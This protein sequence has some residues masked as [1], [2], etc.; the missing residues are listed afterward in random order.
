M[1]AA[2]RALA[3]ALLACALPAAAE[4]YSYTDEQGNRVFTDRPGGRAVELVKPRPTNSMPPAETRPI[5]APEPVAAPT[6]DSAT[7]R[8]SQLEVLTPQPDA[9]IR[10]NAG[11]LLVEVASTPELLPGH[12]YRLLLDG[13]DTE[14]GGGGPQFALQNIDRGTHQLTVQV[15]DESGASLQSS[16]PRTFHMMR[17]S[18]AQRRMARPCKKDDYGVRPECPLKDKPKEKRDIPFVPF[19]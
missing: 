18:L 15:I 19:L 10:D 12:A 2:R 1:N 4:I 8:Y 11:G 3:A 16:P 9:T 13:N 14:L 7:N 5:Q 6:A 17:T